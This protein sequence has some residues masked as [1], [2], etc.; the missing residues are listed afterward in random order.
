MK[1]KTAINPNMV[2]LPAGAD[3]WEETKRMHWFKRRTKNRKLAQLLPKLRG[4]H[5]T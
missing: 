1:Y 5:D 3:E 2:T 4:D